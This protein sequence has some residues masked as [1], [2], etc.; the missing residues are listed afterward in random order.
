M[1]RERLHN[2]FLADGYSAFES[3]VGDLELACRTL[4]STARAIEALLETRT[5]DVVEQT[6]RSQVK[7]I[8][9]TLVYIE[10]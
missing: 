4:N 2:E 8:Y 9:E 10:S 7:E 5:D 3:C 6:L 1:D